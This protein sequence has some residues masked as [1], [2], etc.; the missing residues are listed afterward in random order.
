MSIVNF[1]VVF[2]GVGKCS[3]KNRPTFTY[4]VFIYGISPTQY[5]HILTVSANVPTSPQIA[6]GARVEVMPVLDWPSASRTSCTM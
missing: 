5:C 1:F 6:L 2:F 3:D 4:Q